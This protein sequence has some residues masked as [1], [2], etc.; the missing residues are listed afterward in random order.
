MNFG[1]GDDLGRAEL[2]LV[3]CGAKSR[4]KNQWNKKLGLGAV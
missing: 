3:V 4:V 2:S 1:A